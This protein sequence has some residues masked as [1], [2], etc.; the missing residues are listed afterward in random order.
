ML[1]GDEFMPL[2]PRFDEGHVKADFQFLRNHFSFPPS[3]TPAD[4]DADAQIRTP[5]RPWTRQRPWDRRHKRPP[6]RCTLSITCVAC[7]R[8]IPKNSEAR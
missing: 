3:R 6:F 2:L 1:D 5:V 8:L 4:A 7:S